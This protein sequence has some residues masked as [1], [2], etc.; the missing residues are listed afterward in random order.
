MKSK[1]FFKRWKQG[2]LDLSPEKQIKGKLIG[3]IGGIV[4]LILALITMIYRRMWGFSIFIFFII[5]LQ[6]ITYIST[7]QQL[8]ATREMLKGIEEDLESPKANKE[9]GNHK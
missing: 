8:I 2:I 7:R 9:I 6:V 4:G 5:W 3:I 1:D